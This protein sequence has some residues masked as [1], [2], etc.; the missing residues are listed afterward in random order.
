MAP[1]PEIK[2]L[3][4][5]PGGI[6]RSFKAQIGFSLLRPQDT[7]SPTKAGFDTLVRGEASLLAASEL[8]KHSTT[9]CQPVL[10]NSRAKQHDEPHL[11]LSV[12]KSNDQARL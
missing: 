12:H 10:I 8:A 9:C 5:L 6:N 7:L 1:P 3:R 2:G 11:R 4:L